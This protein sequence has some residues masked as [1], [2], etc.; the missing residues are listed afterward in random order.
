MKT[1]H[2]LTVLAVLAVLALSSVLCACGDDGREVAGG[3]GGTGGTG[4]DAGIGGVGGTGGTGGDAGTGAVS[5]TGGTGGT[6]FPSVTSVTMP[7]PFATKNPN[8]DAEGPG[9]TVHRPATLGEGGLKHP[10]I[11]WGMGTGGF[12]FY[13]PAFELWASH[14]FIVVGDIQGNGQGD[15]V[16]MLGCLDHVCAT[17]APHVDCRAGTTGHS[18]GGGG[19]IMA[20][21]DPRVVVTAPVQPYIQQ[22]FG[23]FDQASID[24]QTGPMLLLSGTLD[25]IATPAVHQQ[26]V[27]DGTNVPVLW[28]NRVGE[29][30]VSVGTDG[31]ESYRSE[32]LAWFRIHL[33]GDD[34]F[35]PMFYG[36]SCELCSDTT[37]WMVQRKGVQ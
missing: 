33:L 27:F 16:E 29:D 28:A 8:G 22:G 21:R 12:N 15:G 1:R 10:V 19:A 24:Q 32:I 20:G 34:T 18:Q 3:V 7:G 25:N 11:V 17:Y 6:G 35:R 37:N 14:G 36:A 5:G 30:H 2:P 4:G 9:C 13:Q 31:L 23:G 26:P